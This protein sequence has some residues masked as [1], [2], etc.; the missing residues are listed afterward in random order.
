MD[1][2]ITHVTRY[3]YE[4]PAEEAFLETRLSPML[5]PFQTTRDHRLELDPGA[6]LSE[7][8]D[9]FGNH[10][11][12]F[13]IP[14]RHD[15]LTLTSRSR[16][17]TRPRPLPAGAE[18]PIQEARQI[19]S[20]A[21]ADHFHYLLH[22]EVVSASAAAASWARRHLAGARPLGEAVFALSHA[23]HTGFRYLSG[24]TEV[25]T[26]L[27]EVWR[28]KKGVC[29]DFAHVAL[30]VLRTAGLI[31]RYV[32]GYIETDPPRGAR[33]LTGS[34]ATHAWVEVLAPGM[35]W[36]AVDP[37]NDQWC[38]E[39]HVTVAVGR[40]YR[41]AAPVRGTFKGNGSQSIAVAVL[42]R[43]SPEDHPAE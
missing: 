22:N 37:T 38:G 26:P 13:T 23:I 2:Q 39:R 11:G 19:L 41:D 16:V 30:S 6:E 1:F 40:D 15:A 34:A 31:C 27:I 25:S 28:R 3:R 4:Q 24:S 5:R 18:V 12:F 9:A 42:M 33:R 10:T 17:S 7:Y 35:E 43:R 36:L 20:S 8:Q 21:H 29:Q 32:C 14:F